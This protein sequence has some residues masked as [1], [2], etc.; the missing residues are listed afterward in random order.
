MQVKRASGKDFFEW[1]HLIRH[2]SKKVAK[3]LMELVK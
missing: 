2:D 3:I 1:P